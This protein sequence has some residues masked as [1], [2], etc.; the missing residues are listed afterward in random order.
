MNEFLSSEGCL[1][2]FTFFV[3]ILAQKAYQR[4]DVVYLNP[5]LLAIISVIAFLMVTDI[6]YDEYATKTKVISFWLNPS[7]VA[8]AIP[9]YLQMD[10]IKK[11]A[12]RIFL[13]TL[14]GGFIGIVS[15]VIVARLL[16]ASEEIFLSLAPKSVSTPIA[17]SISE[18]IGGLPPLTTAVVVVV[19]ILG[20]VM[21]EQI[22]RLFGIID[23]HAVGLA[24]GTSSHALGTAKIAVK[25][26]AY[27][28]YSA[29]GLALNGIITSLLTPKLLPFIDKLF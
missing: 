6:S 22:L 5:V 16:G 25:G 20:A 17:L 11:D 1:V 27:G 14:S 28:S 15:V 4:L 7:V 18:T 19:G 23:P 26:D 24:I 3:Y 29:I 21:G 9:L 12:W 13:A 10:K 8:L 2:G